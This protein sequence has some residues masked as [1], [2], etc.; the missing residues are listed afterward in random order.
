MNELDAAYNLVHDYPGG[1]DS[2]APRVGKNATTLCHEVA[3]VG[4]AKLG[5]Q[6]S[7]KLSVASGDKRILEAFAMQCGFMLLPLPNALA[8]SKDTCME[9]LGDL[10]RESSEV[11]R[12]TVAG[13]ADGELSDNERGRIERDCALLVSSVSAFMCAVDARHMAGKR[14]GQLGQQVA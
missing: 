7:V 1:A 9:R 12:E 14:A 2:L 11:V 13:L 4:T 10:L 8:L 6:T 5:L 3:R